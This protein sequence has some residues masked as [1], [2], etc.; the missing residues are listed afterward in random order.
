MVRYALL[1]TGFLIVTVLPWEGRVSAEPSTLSDPSPA[2]SLNDL[3]LEDEVLVRIRDRKFMPATVRVHAGRK[4]KLVFHNQDAELHAFVPGTLFNGISLN[5][6]G[7]GAPEFGDQG[8][9]KVIIP[10]E[11]IVELRFVLSQP[12]S[13]PFICDMPGHE[14]RA[15][16]VVE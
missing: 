2:L 8:F 3:I 7:N 14:M 6:A 15:T 9:R 16:I 5:V 11:G 10:G 12:G 4:T 1:I 13:Y